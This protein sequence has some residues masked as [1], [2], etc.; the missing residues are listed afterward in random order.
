MFKDIIDLISITTT[1]NDI[2][3]TV[4]VET[5]K[6]VYANKKSIKQSEYYQALSA[7]LKPV[8]T[9][10]IHSFEYEGE[11]K[12]TYSTKPYNIIRTFEKGD[13]IELICEAV[14]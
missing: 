14:V 12:L 7:G 4:E 2:G 5:A 6:Q 8:V 3:D 9:F 10:V 11:K 13:F 1:T